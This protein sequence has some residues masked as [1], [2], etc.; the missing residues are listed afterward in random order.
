MFHNVST[1]RM[2]Q[3][4]RCI[5][6]IFTISTTLIILSGLAYAAD[7]KKELKPVGRTP[8]A[9]YEE[10]LKAELLATIGEYQGKS[11]GIVDTSKTAGTSSNVKIIAKQ[12]KK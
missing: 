5:R 10:A 2:F 11:P 3:M 6:T 12:P 9:K 8:E 7:K 1:L 4:D